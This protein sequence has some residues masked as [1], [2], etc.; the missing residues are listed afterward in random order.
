MVWQGLPRDGLQS[1]QRLFNTCSALSLR[2]NFICQHTRTPHASLTPNRRCSSRAAS[3]AA[4]YFSCS[5]LPVQVTN[6]CYTRP[7]KA[8]TTFSGACASSTLTREES[9]VRDRARAL[10]SRKLSTCRPSPVPAPVLME[11][12]RDLP[13]ASTSTR[14]CQTPGWPGKISS[15]PLLPFFDPAAIARAVR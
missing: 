14:R 5:F 10:R 15:V 4:A 6:A 3:C 7:L 11:S 12:A 13:R 1:R 2:I 9:E 8:F